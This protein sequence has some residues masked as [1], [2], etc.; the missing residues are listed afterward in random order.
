M[1]Q[2]TLNVVIFYKY[3]DQHYYEGL[4]LKPAHLMKFKKMLQ[5]FL[6]NCFQKKTMAVKALRLKIRQLF[7]GSKLCKY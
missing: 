1:D 5:F 4:K 2:A 3:Q 7:N 6:P